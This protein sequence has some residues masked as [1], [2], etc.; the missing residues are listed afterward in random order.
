MGWYDVFARFYDASLEGQYVEQRAAATEALELSPGLHVLDV[1]CGTGQSFDGIAPAIADGGM[2]VGADLSGG[3]LGRARARVQRHG[4]KHVHLVESDVHALDDDA[5]AKQVGRALSFDRLHVFLGMTAF[6]SW[7]DAFANLWN[8]LAPGGRAV[9]VDVHAD[10]PGFQ[11]R[12]VN[13]VAR[14]DITRPWW[15]PLE[16]VARDYERTE[17]P[18]TWQHGGKIFLAT[19]IKPA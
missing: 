9:I 14:A 6:P 16:A 13:L 4:W 2:L 15:T 10:E 11:G 1:P 7:E 5:I 18:S 17:L 8:L 19:G 12:M 3:M